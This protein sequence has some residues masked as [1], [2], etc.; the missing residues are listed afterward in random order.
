MKRSLAVVLA[1]GTLL[2]AGGCA[3]H[4]GPSGVAGW[5]YKTFRESPTALPE[6]ETELNK[7]AAQGWIV[8]Q[9]LQRGDAPYVTL[10]LKRPKQ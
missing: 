3:T 1:A 4:C 8:D 5:E 2:L 7:L 9:V 6:F 10:L